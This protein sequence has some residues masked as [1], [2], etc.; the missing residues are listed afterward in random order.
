MASNDS[1]VTRKLLSKKVINQ[2]V[3]DVAV[4]IRIRH[5]SSDAVT[6]VTLTSTTNLVLID[7]AGTTTSTFSTDTTLGAVVDRINASA[8]WEAIILDAKRSDASASTLLP[9]SAITASTYDGVSY[10]DALTDT[11]GLDAMAV[12]LCYSRHTPSG[13]PVKGAHRVIFQD[14]TYDVTLGGGADA[15]GL[16]LYEV[17]GAT[18]TEI[19]RSTPTTG[20]SATLFSN[21][22]LDSDNGITS[23]DGNEI[24]VQITDSTSITGSMHVF[25]ILE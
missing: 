1:L 7:A 5:I 8:N 9:N 12:R 18:E 11:S 22:L 4:A 25:G 20:S 2:N 14:V 13:Q 24:L 16:K 10:Y 17:D 23:K 15:D 21:A 3:D 6:S 19:W